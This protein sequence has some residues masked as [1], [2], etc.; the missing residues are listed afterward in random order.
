[1]FDLMDNV[2]DQASMGYLALNR[3][4]LLTC[5]DLTHNED[6]DP[7][8]IDMMQPSHRGV[9]HLDVNRRTGFIHPGLSS[10]AVDQILGHD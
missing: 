3:W 7:S 2:L 6:L 10:D 1:M 9:T 8:M 4:D 5:L